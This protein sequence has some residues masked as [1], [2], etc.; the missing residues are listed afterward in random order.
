MGT[1]YLSEIL[2]LQARLER[3]SRLNLGDVCY[4]SFEDDHLT[5]AADSCGEIEAEG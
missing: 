4:E 5:G 2:R 1:L 3:Y